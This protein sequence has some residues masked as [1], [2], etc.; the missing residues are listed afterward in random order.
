MKFKYQQKIKD[1]VSISKNKINTKPVVID[2]GNIYKYNQYS[3]MGLVKTE[4]QFD[5]VK[6]VSDS[7]IT[8]DNIIITN[9]TDQWRN[10][11]FFQYQLKYDCI[12]PENMKVLVHHFYVF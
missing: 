5:T 10:P 8:N 9:K 6:Y 2:Y 7:S 12:Y 3:V 1:F 4:V 11:L